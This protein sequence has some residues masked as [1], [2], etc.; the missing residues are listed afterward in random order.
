[1]YL[2]PEL[3]VVLLS[4][5]FLSTLLSNTYVRIYIRMHVTYLLTYGGLCVYIHM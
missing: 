1:M 3:C 5:H 2:Q 4:L